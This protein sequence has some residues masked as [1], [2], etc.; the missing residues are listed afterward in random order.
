[1]FDIGGWHIKRVNWH[2][3]VTID[4]PKGNALIRKSI[5]IKYY[6]NQKSK[7]FHKTAKL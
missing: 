1:M 3:F 6:C 4:L 7:K 5:K 2:C